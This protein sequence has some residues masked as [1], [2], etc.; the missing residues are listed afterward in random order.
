ML[1]PF[2]NFFLLNIASHAQ[3]QPYWATLRK[4][5]EGFRRVIGEGLAPKALAANSKRKPG[6]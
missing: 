2:R 3:E 4:G 6:K 1:C 5:L